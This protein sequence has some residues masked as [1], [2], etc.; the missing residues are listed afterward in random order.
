VLH[1]KHSAAQP[2]TRA[3]SQQV[4]GEH[5]LGEVVRVLPGTRLRAACSAARLS[6]SRHSGSA[7]SQTTLITPRA[8]GSLGPLHALYKPQKLLR[9]PGFLHHGLN[10]Q[11]PDLL[12]QL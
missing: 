4:L 12:Q 1:G 2:E 8:S 7:H 3:G 6:S 9:L 5:L 11:R 10:P